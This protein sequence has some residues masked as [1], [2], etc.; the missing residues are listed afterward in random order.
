MKELRVQAERWRV[1]YN[2]MRPHSSLS[3]RSPTSEAWLTNS[4][5]HREA[6]AAKRFPLLHTPT[7]TAELRI[8]AL[9]QLIQKHKR[10]GTPSSTRAFFD[11]NE[12]GIHALRAQLLWLPPIL[13]AFLCFIVGFR[14]AKS[15]PPG[16]KHRE[17]DLKPIQGNTMIL[18][19]NHGG[20]PLIA[21]TDCHDC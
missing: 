7:A 9:H 4:V 16:P 12:N 14:T 10:S 21:E 2:T 5:G 8:A 3:Y 15:P 20:S 6:E 17:N 18:E 13:L 11:R 1:H 19:P